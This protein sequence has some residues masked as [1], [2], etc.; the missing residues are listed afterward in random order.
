MIKKLL[1]DKGHHLNDDFDL[2]RDYRNIERFIPI[3]KLLLVLINHF[4]GEANKLRDFE[5]DFYKYLMLQTFYT[6][7]EH[8]FI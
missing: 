2:L 4:D 3:Q 1:K 6:L 5:K 8:L 7:T